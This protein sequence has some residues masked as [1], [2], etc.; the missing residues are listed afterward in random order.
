MQ[1]GASAPDPNIT[2][3]PTMS[4]VDLK[5]LAQEA[6][7]REMARR[8]VRNEA[9]RIKTPRRPERPAE[10]PIDSRIELYGIVATPHGIS[11]MVNDRILNE[12]DRIFGAIVKKITTNTVIFEYK[13]RTFYKRVSK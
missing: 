6:L 8:Q 9:E 4:P 7:Q 2:R 11:A 3:D 10:P 12:G 5:R 13:K 1:A